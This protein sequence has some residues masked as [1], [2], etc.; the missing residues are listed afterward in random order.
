M[1]ETVISSSAAA[2]IDDGGLTFKVRIEPHGNWTTD[3]DV[4]TSRAGAGGTYARPKYERGRKRA[5]P[6]MGRSLER[7]LGDAPRLECDNGPLMATYRRSLVDLAALRFSPP[8][9]G[10]KSLPAAGCRGS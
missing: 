5:R 1:R 10:G 9:A 3:L 8:V 2:D 6:N 4:V 7:W